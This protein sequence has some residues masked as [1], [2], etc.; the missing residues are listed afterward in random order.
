ML[1]ADAA[2]QPW[3]Q[4]AALPRDRV[5]AMLWPGAHEQGWRVAPTHQGGSDK[6]GKWTYVSPSGS[7]LPNRLQA[8]LHF[9]DTSLAPQLGP[10]DAEPDVEFP[11]LPANTASRASADAQSSSADVCAEHK[12]D[13]LKAL[14]DAGY[15]FGNTVDSEASFVKED[16]VAL[17]SAVLSSATSEVA[18]VPTGLVASHAVW[19]PSAALALLARGAWTVEFGPLLT[20]ADKFDELGLEVPPWQ[21]AAD[22]LSD[23]MLEAHRI[24]PTAMLSVRDLRSGAM[25]KRPASWVVDQFGKPEEK[26]T[27]LLNCM[28]M[29]QPTDSTAQL[30]AMPEALE[31]LNLS[32][33]WWP[34][35]STF[36]LL[37]MKGALLIKALARSPPAPSPRTPYPVPFGRSAPLRPPVVSNVLLTSSATQAARHRIT[38]SSGAAPYCT[39]SCGAAN[40][41]SRRRPRPPTWR[42]SAHGATRARGRTSLRPRA[43]PRQQGMPPA[44]Q[45]GSR[46]RSC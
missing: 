43:G 11:W 16:E 45:R 3:Q 13:S 9:T 39:W 1:P 23:K 4:A 31:R 38:S 30:A 35:A 5:D 29:L 10:D 25:M 41:S 27:S 36:L 18:A 24:K 40:S 21:S 7:S 26:R 44:F 14:R 12:K 19:E 22:M 32:R 6:S 33:H 2:L 8:V 17:A 37:S 28:H 46:M 42:S 34:N 20:R 15:E